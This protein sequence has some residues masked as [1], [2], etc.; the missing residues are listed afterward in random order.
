MP[1]LSVIGRKSLSQRLLVG[2]L[3]LVLTVLGATMV[4]P[5]LITV[6]NS[7]SNDFD[8]DRFSIVPRSLWSAEDR[9]CKSLPVFINRYQGW[10]AVLQAQ[11]PG[12]PETWTS[13]RTIGLDSKRS[14]AVA[15]AYLRPQ[16]GQWELWKKQA[17]DYAEFSAGYPLED[18]LTTFS[19]EQGS[20]LVA[21]A[22]ERVW[23]E[24][25]PEAARRAG[26]AQRQQAALNLLS[27]NWGVPIPNFFV[28]HFL[29]EIRSPLTQQS[30]VPPFTAKQA[31]YTLIQQAVRSGYGT[32]G[33]IAKWTG[34]LREKGY[35][36]ADARALAP[37]PID[38]AP[39]IKK[40]WVE[41][42]KEKAPAS[43]VIPNPLRLAWNEYLGSDEA[44]EILGIGD[45]DRFDISYYN[46]ISG[47]Q[48]AS[49]AATP[50]P[51]PAEGF[52]KLQ[53]LWTK[54]VQDRYPLRLTTITV[55]PELEEQ[56]QQ[57]LQ[58]YPSLE[59]VNALLGT[60]HASWQEF[61]LPSQMPDSEAKVGVWMNFVKTLPAAVRQIRSSEAAYQ[62]FLLQKYGSLGK[63]NETYGWK[64]ERIEEA[65]PPYDKA[66]AITIH[67]NSTSFAWAP[68]L[69]NYGTMT[70]FLV[71][72][73]NAIPVTLWLIFL[74]ILVTLTVNPIAGYALSRFNLKGKDK[75]IL[76]CLATSAF[77][78]MVSA[79][80]GYLLMRDL[81]L[82]NT[83]FALVL[84]GA[85][86]G[87]SIFILKGFFDSLPPEL[88]EAATIDGAREWQ[89][90]TYVTIPMLTPILAI[91]AL[92]AFLGAYG[93][94]EWA[95]IICQDPRMWTLSVWLYQANEWWVQ[96]PWITTAGFVIASIPTL[97]VFLFCQKIIMRGII[98]PSMK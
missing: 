40:L 33:V 16:P 78:A 12:V 10:F 59:N 43:P 73:G 91:N 61:R 62:Q 15:A 17:A 53:P 56:Y 38:A 27:Q 92:N 58:T 26:A 88:Y 9:F 81:G 5:F 42:A 89:I 85:A 4:V 45:N 50:F 48:Y 44:R 23:A 36:K 57:F 97:F 76:F 64:L 98:V 60:T 51:L 1:I 67:E 2:L 95:L 29:G 94:W 93:G 54:F 31:D 11:F 69:E 34:F 49:L 37:L 65:F 84:P 24:K 72:R 7:N 63:V 25:N 39:D 79:I 86:S 18:S 22:Y 13:W 68:L 46:R 35:S 75:I 19:N 80:P 21:L 28:V 77:P 47:T 8:Y 74:S 66:C 20:R 30:W 55:T 82:L 90:F 14:D 52:E 71:S 70:N 87:M 32:P 96:T 83:F 41:F 3:Y 6:T